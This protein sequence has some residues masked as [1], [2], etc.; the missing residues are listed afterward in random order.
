M[1]QTKL[2]TREKDVEIVMAA[3]GMKATSPT[4]RGLVY[5]NL[6]DITICQY[7]RGVDRKGRFLFSKVVLVT[8]AASAIAWGWASKIFLAPYP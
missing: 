2:E 3:D 4:E 1:T 5:K 8:L 6:G 7:T